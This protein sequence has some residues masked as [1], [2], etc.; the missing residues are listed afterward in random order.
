MGKLLVVGATGLLGRAA[1]K[2]FRAKKGWICAGLSRRPHKFRNV[3]YLARDLLDNP[4]I[5]K[6]QSKLRDVTHILYAALY[7]MDDLL[8]GWR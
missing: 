7:E 3:E 2:Y 8:S 5:E 4:S 6:H 1:I